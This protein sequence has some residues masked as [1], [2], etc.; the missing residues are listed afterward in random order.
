[1][2]GYKE[3]DGRKGGRRLVYKEEYG[4]IYGRRWPE[5]RKKMSRYKEEDGQT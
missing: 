2:A 1:M 5:M 3:I 4:R